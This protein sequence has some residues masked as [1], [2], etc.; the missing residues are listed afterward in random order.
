MLQL[1]EAGIRVVSAD[2][3]DHSDDESSWGELIRY[4]RGKAAEDEV[5]NI[6]HRTMG[7][8]RAKA[9]GDPEKGIPPMLICGGHSRYG[10]KWVTNDKGRKIG[11]EPDHTVIYVSQDGIEWTGVDVIKFLFQSSA[12]GATIKRIA[13]TLNEMGVPSPYKLKGIQRRDAHKAIWQPS[14]IARMLRDKGYAGEVTLF[15][16]KVV[17]K[18]SNAKRPGAKSEIREKTDPSEQVTIEIP[19]IISIELYQQVQKQLDKNKRQAGRNNKNPEDFLMRS[20]LAF[21]GYCGSRMMG[22][23]RVRKNKNGT[24]TPLF[25]YTCIGR[26][27]QLE[28]CKG[29]WIDARIV[30][31]ATWEKVIEIIDNPEVVDE[32]VTKKRKKDPTAGNRVKIKTK[33]KEIEAQQ[34]TFRTQLRDLMLK[35]VLDQGTQE[36]LSTELKQLSERLQEWN[37]KLIENEDVHQEWKKIEDKLNDVHKTCRQLSEQ[38]HDPEYAPTYQEKR[39]LV[40]FFKIT[41][42][43]WKA[44]HSPRFKLESNVVDIVTDLSCLAWPVT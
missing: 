6:R 31:R 33:I 3:E 12:N 11:T 20:G 22:K 40:E 25:G 29:C 37:T 24:E 15:K 7:G 36:F 35:G 44:D 41:A 28:K 5:K 17:G 14:A 32:A 30:D 9:T 8:R 23:R 13:V 21:C 27:G 39:D 19:S 43:I 1:K 38:I 34:E 4:L 2:P 18:R 16:E 26:Y 10:Y 42:T